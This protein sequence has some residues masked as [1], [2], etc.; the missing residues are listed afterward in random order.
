MPN[1]TVKGFNIGGTTV[2]YDYNSLENKL[3]LDNTLSIANAAADAKA[4]G[5][6]F[7]E[8]KESMS[9]TRNLLPMQPPDG[10]KTT[11]DLGSEKTFS[12]GCSISFDLVGV[13]PNAS[14]A[15][16]TL[17]REDETNVK[18]ITLNNVRNI[19]TGVQFPNE[20]GS[21][22][23]RYS[24]IDIADL[25]SS[26]TFRYIVINTT[27]TLLPAGKAKNFML[28]AGPT[29]NQYIPYKDYPDNLLQEDTVPADI[30]ANLHNL[31][32]WNA[33][34]R[35]DK[36]GYFRDV[37]GQ[38]L[39]NSSYFCTRLFIAR[40]GDVLRYS[41]SH[42]NTLPLLQIYDANKQV[43]SNVTG[44]G[45]GNIV[46]GTHTFT[47]EEKF[48]S[49]SGVNSQKWQYVLQYNGNPVTDVDIPAYWETAIE[50]A[51]TEIL[52]NEIVSDSCVSFFFVTDAHWTSN[53]QRSTEIIKELSDRVSTKLVLN[54][55]DMIASK[56]VTKFG[57]AQEINNYMKTWA[58]TNLRVF[59]TVGNH[60]F[61]TVG[62]L[63]TDTYLTANNLY[64]LI[65][66][67]QEPWMDTKNTIYCNYFDN[68][69]AKVRFIQF[70]YT[71]D[72]GYIA[73]VASAL[74]EAL[75]ETPTG[76]SVVLLSHAYWNLTTPETTA[77]TYA[78][79]ILDTMDEMGAEVALWICGHTHA[80]RDTTLTS[81]GGKKL[82]IVSTSTDALGQNPISPAM[83]RGDATEQVIDYV[84][85]DTENKTVKLTRIGAGQS[86]LFTY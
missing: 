37:Y 8:I 85:I 82:L 33:D 17:K 69:S 50:V 16:I 58:S 19:E 81:N 10:A 78:D 40:P 86:R 80:D 36:T 77:T 32:I 6:K 3:E 48:F 25:T 21:R 41:L 59:S 64:N 18:V 70:Y 75:T 29:P 42:G 34:Y 68:D 79:I 11:I 39:A 35:Q 31:L 5:D 1:E 46:A 49:V 76:W 71:V 13:T 63:D 52:G 27:T 45:T 30:W 54:G 65:M 60:D 66:R 74:T 62:N 22:T 61:N 12:S 38:L 56:N 15:F 2:K 43:L 23:G 72:S 84:Q 9:I 28:T 14:A 67:S 57:A 7:A 47:N 53:A 83:T 4:T 44:I 73:D 55:G 20:T 51:E 24:T 26:I